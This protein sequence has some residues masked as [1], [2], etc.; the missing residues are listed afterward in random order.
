VRMSLP[1]VLKAAKSIEVLW[2]LPQCRRHY[3]IGYASRNAIGP[4]SSI[5]SIHP[6]GVEQKADR[7]RRRH[8]RNAFLG[9]ERGPSFLQVQ[10][11]EFDL[12]NS[13]F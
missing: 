12:S 11:P 4:Q 13:T 5:R 3:G 9:M 10:P 1:I 6:V 8:F 2:S 7:P